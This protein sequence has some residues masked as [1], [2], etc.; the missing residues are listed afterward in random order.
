MLKN[1]LLIE[2]NHDIAMSIKKY[3]ELEHI[4]VDIAENGKTGLELFKKN[5]YDIVLLDIMLPEVDGVSVCKQIKKVSDVPIIMTTAKWQLEDKLELF[6][7][8]ADDYLV[9][10]FDLEE[11]MARIHALSRR[12]NSFTTFSRGNITIDLQKRKIEKSNKEV[13]VTIKE[14]HIVEIL[15]NNYGM[16][17]SRAD[18]IEHVWWGDEVWQE[19]G[20]LDVYI[21]TIRK[22]LDKKLI[23]TIPG[24]WYKIEK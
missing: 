23:T 3:I 21:S 1:I 17:V 4:A 2:D 18:I 22:K 14:F 6:D 10:P 5:S 11:L 12:N 9:K 7:A 13:Y 16:P 19:N 20:K 8:G 15:I 24:F